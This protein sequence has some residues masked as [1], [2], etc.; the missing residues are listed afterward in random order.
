MRHDRCK[1]CYHEHVW[2]SIANNVFLVIYKG[3]MGVLTGCQALIADAFHSSADLIASIITL[4]S[5]K[6]SEKPPDAD[7]HYGH[8]KIQFLSSSIVGLILLV[9]GIFILINALTSVVTGAYAEPDP[10]AL[11][12]AAVSVAMNEFLFRYQSCVG[13]ENNSPA[14]MANA[15]DNRSDAFSSMAVL[16]GISLAIFGLPIADPLAAIGVSMVVAK[17]GIDLILE[18]IDGLMDASLGMDELKAI[19]NVVNKVP[20][21]RGVSYMRGRTMGDRLHVEVDVMVPDTLKVYEGDLIVDLLRQRIM[22]EVEHMGELEIFLSPVE[23]AE[24]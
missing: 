24:A 21:I 11:L 12:G 6:I 2:Y 7:H 15:W 14:I 4:F 8:G 17:I 16:V 3:V 1:S 13:R 18:A 22:D 20:G 23:V 19:H 9:G 10:I 5:L